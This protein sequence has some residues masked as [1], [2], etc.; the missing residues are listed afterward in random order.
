[1]ESFN[2]IYDKYNSRIEKEGILYEGALYRKVVYNEVIDFKYDTYLFVGFNV[3]QK[4][5]QR[6]FSKIKKEH[7]A[8]VLLG[9]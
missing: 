9:L 8:K 5:E 7:K 1:M 6:L 2:E 3:L 4:V